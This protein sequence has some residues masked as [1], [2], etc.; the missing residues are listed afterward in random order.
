[1]SITI[2]GTNETGKDSNGIPI[3]NSQLPNINAKSA[4]IYIKTLDTTKQNILDSLTTISDNTRAIWGTSSSNIVSPNQEYCIYYYT[5]YSSEYKK[6]AKIKVYV[7]DIY[8]LYLN[9]ESIKS[10]IDHSYD[11][12]D[13]SKIDSTINILKGFNFFKFICKNISLDGFLAFV[14]FDN[15]NNFLFNTNSNS[16]TDFRFGDLGG[17]IYNGPITYNYLKTPINILSTNIGWTATLPSN[18]RY[19]W[20]TNSPNNTIKYTYN[21]VNNL[22]SNILIKLTILVDNFCSFISN[23][24]VMKVFYSTF[25]ATKTDN[26]YFI[27]LL[28]NSTN[29]FEFY[30]TNTGGPAGVAIS[31]TKNSDNSL[32]FGTTVD[33]PS[34]LNLGNYPYIYGSDVSSLPN[35]L[36]QTAGIYILPFTSTYVTYLLS[37]IDSTN[38]TKWIWNNYDGVYTG[39]IYYYFTYYSNT[40][41]NVDLYVFALGNRNVYVNNIEIIYTDNSYLSSQSDS[42]Y[43]NTI[44]LYKG[45]NFLKF[46]ISQITTPSTINNGC[47]AFICKDSN[48]NILFNTNVDS[49]ND[50]QLLYNTYLGINSNLEPIFI[51][52]QTKNTAWTSNINEYDVSNPSSLPTKYIWNDANCETIADIST[53]KYT[54]KYNSQVITT[55]KLYIYIDEF[56]YVIVN[57]IY[58]GLITKTFRTGNTNV[59]DNIDITIG[60]NYFE[61][62]CTNTIGGA[63]F[64]MICLSNGVRLFNTN[65][66]SDTDSNW[67]Y[68]GINFGYDYSGILPNIMATSA[69]VYVLSTVDSSITVNKNQ[70]DIVGYSP[71]GWIYNNVQGIAY[72]KTIYY[73]TYYSDTYYYNVSFYIFA[74]NICSVYINNKPISE[75]LDNSYL[76]GNVNLIGASNLVINIG[77]NFIK[78]VCVSTDYGAIAFICKTSTKVLFNTN[79]ISNTDLR[80]ET[81]YLGVNE[82]DIQPINVISDI[83]TV[84]SISGSPTTKYIWNGT[85][86]IG[87]IKYTFKYNSLSSLTNVKLYIYVCNYCTV[88]LN[89]MYK[90]IIGNSYLSTETNNYLTIDLNSG[91]NYFT[92]YCTNLTTLCGIA[93]L[94][95]DSSGNYLFNTN[96]NTPTDTN[97]NSIP[98]IF[99]NNIDLL[100]SNDA[101]SANVYPLTSSITTDMASYDSTMKWI[102]SSQNND[103][104]TLYYYFTYYSDSYISNANIYIF[105]QDVYSLYVNNIEKKTNSLYGTLEYSQITLLKGFNFL[106]I[107][108]SNNS[109]IGCFAMTCKDGTTVLFNTN[110]NSDKDP[111]FKNIYLG[112]TYSYDYTPIVNITDTTFSKNITVSGRTTTPTY[113]WSNL[114]TNIETIKY[115][116]FLNLTVNKPN[117]K[118]YIYIK[119]YCTFILNDVYIGI[120]SNSYINGNN[121]FFTINL[122]SGVNYFKFYCTNNKDETCGFA[123]ICVDSSNNNLFYTNTSSS[124]DDK[125]FRTPMYITNNKP[126]DWSTP[127]KY[128]VVSVTNP[129]KWV[130]N[131]SNAG[132]AVSMYDK[133]TYY[134]YYN[135]TTET[136][137]NIYILVDGSCDFYLNDNFKGT[138][139]GTQTD[140]SLTPY[141]TGLNII[142][143]TNEF[144]FECINKITTDTGQTPASIAILCIDTSNNFIFNTNQYSMINNSDSWKYRNYIKYSYK[145]TNITE[146]ITKTATYETRDYSN[147]IKNFPRSSVWTSWTIPNNFGFK[148][149]GFDI[150][151]YCHA[152]YYEFTNSGSYKGAL[153]S[154]VNS[155]KV[156][157]VSG[158]QGGQGGQGAAVYKYDT[159]KGE[160]GNRGS[161]GN[162]G[163]TNT[164]YIESI[165][166]RNFDISVG[167]GGSGGN[168]G[169]GRQYSTGPKHHYNGNYG[170]PGMP[171]NFI[172]NNITYSTDASNE[173]TI[174]DKQYYSNI[175]NKTYFSSELARGGNGGEGGSNGGQHSGYPGETGKPGYCRVYLLG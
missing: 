66:N 15:N 102:W 98:Y 57:D 25:D 60:D 30:C 37:T 157:C 80:F 67:I 142:D 61:F 168:G 83:G 170:T 154:W 123:T 155:V 54:Y 122:S 43:K 44:K 126:T 70:Y 10:N 35:I 138:L 39:D 51:L 21:Y 50:S 132:S 108:C 77:F 6:D 174:K 90:G 128:D 32:L 119:N 12:T 143:D 140:A 41:Q 81:I 49:W 88:I 79:S 99:G 85:T 167:N 150:S 13:S 40:T 129:T 158:G 106:K 56:C 133:F 58:K 18:I 153:P 110:N 23:G 73:Y 24:V 64:A 22:S 107:K 89:S 38:S 17:L 105:V 94:C 159:N 74:K 114:N 27:N 68:Y 92:F 130:W 91:Y 118:I 175:T 111:R 149:G 16:V 163:N 134:Y 165:N 76:S 156:I 28:A 112:E 124:S 169:G 166:N 131:V 117:S 93:I 147:I 160:E 162:A 101:I 152:K 164:Y 120:I 45:F 33:S 95:V 116:Y 113:I 84:T 53:I 46:K 9:N 146:M 109:G 29:Y 125:W 135:S 59:I 36:A 139:S 161:A 7:D 48:N 71:T 86:T 173:N 78:I 42:T 148:I 31:C 3:L 65:S 115:D 144:R 14:C 137:C 141:I 1:M 47:F 52:D 5:Y 145:G 72:N 87:T 69:D 151:T 62:Y 26:T 63:G 103:I 75:N 20:Y 82:Y 34:D 104:G 2:Y 11:M 171:T 55:C 19:I 4:S 136:T 8:W 127:S 121:D 172:I 97:W 100:P 96:N